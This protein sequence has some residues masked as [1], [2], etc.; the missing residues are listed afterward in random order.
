LINSKSVASWTL[1]AGCYWGEVLL[2]AGAEGETLLARF[3][4]QEKGRE[5]SEPGREIG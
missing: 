1:W 5:K 4:F 2:I 3:D